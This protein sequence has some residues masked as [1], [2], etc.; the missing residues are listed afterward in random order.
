[1]IS[2]APDRWQGY[3]RSS[4]LFLSIGKTEKSI[5]L[6]DAATRKAKQGS[7]AFE[8]L[9]K[10]K[11]LIDTAILQRPAQPS[12]SVNELPTELLADIFLLA[13]SDS[14]TPQVFQFTINTVSHV[15]R[16]W[17]SIAFGT[18]SLWRTLVLHSV[19]PVAK[20]R[21]FVQRS[22]NR[23]HGIHMRHSLHSIKEDIIPELR[24]V[25]WQHVQSFVMESSLKIS[26][27]TVEYI[28]SGVL[29]NVQEVSIVDPD[30]LLLA[31]TNLEP[32]L[33]TLNPRLRTFTFELPRL[34]KL[35]KI[36]FSNIKTLNLKIS[37]SEG[38]WDDLVAF[39]VRNSELEDLRLNGNHTMSRFMPDSIDE[40]FTLQYVYRLH[41]ERFSRSVPFFDNIT[42]PALRELILIG[43]GSL[44]DK[45]ARQITQ[46]IHLTYLD[47]QTCYVSANDMN[48][49]L[50]GSADLETLKLNHIGDAVQEIVER[51]SSSSTICPNLQHLDL[52][53]CPDITTSPLHR[54]VKDRLAASQVEGTDQSEALPVKALVSLRVDGCPKIEAELI[55]WFRS[56]LKEFSCAYMTRKAASYKR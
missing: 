1:V 32:L 36:M 25:R 47:V 23:L 33:A 10:L 20:A 48:A 30:N 56:R 15:C 31:N 28:G 29:Q 12:L 49:L 43:C 4:R 14:E 26:K 16:H 46:P 19:R 52:S 17:R 11:E 7:K 35:Q 2:L 13:A 18:S 41:L 27:S 53:F 34:H 44:L 24:R 38:R 54:L 42:F 40:K 55:P 9:S 8:E 3:Y 39:V 51:L 50:S 22:K 45:F 37:E 5:L 6:Y 21:F